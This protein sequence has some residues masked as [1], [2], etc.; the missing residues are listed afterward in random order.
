MKVRLRPKRFWISIKT[1]NEISYLGN[2]ALAPV[3]SFRVF[4]VLR[5]DLGPLDGM[6]VALVA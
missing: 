4:R 3:V 2:N 6:S 5:A 1:V